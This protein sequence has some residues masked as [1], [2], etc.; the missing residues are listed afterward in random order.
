MD[1]AV[2]TNRQTLTQDGLIGYPEALAKMQQRVEAIAA[3][4]QGELLWLVEH[5]PLYTAGT[6]A[7]PADLHAPARFPTYQT[8]R[9]GQW[10]YHGPG[11]RVAYV[12][13][14]LKQAH[15]SI[16]ARDVRQFVWGL[17]EVVIRTIAAFGLR[18]ERRAGRVGI[19]VETDAGDAK[20]GAIGVRVSRWVSYHGLS[21]NVAP[22][23][24]HFAGIVPCGISAHGV[25]SL[26]A[27]GHEVSMDALD[28]VLQSSFDQIFS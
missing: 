28:S 19:W 6:S 14:D 27:L 11:Q 17:E 10:T 3:G 7:L 22:D 23:L 16:P 15:G 8:G 18:G 2:S 1:H 24:E 20:I 25:T 13:L 9:G 12:M 4:T 5:P 21:I 26:A